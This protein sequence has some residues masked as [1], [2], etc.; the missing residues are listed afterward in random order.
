[1]KLPPAGPTQ[2]PEPPRAGAAT[3]TDVLSMSPANGGDRDDVDLAPVSGVVQ[4][5]P[6]PST[7]D[8]QL[9]QAAA[10]GHPGAAR[11]IWDRYARLVRS[12]LRRSMGPEGEV[13]DLLQEVFLRFFE[14]AGTLRD[15]GAL[16]SF[17]VGITLRVA[18]D[19]LRKRRVRRILSLTDSGELPESA[20]STDDLGARDALRRLYRILDELRP[21][22]R[23][24]W[25]LRHV[26]GYELADIGQHLDCSLATV[27]RRLARADELVDKRCA[28]DPL[29]RAYR[30]PEGSAR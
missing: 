12:L 24:A 4:A 14:R 9:V 3:H 28:S 15:M 22:A 11:V 25:L 10:A 13:E 29:L 16:R 8:T 18:R 2:F 20:T 1:M 27:K 7:D 30:V 26:E 23:L 17:V 21:S 5:F 19:A 6:L